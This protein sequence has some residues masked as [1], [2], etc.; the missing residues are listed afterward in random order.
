MFEWIKSLLQRVL[1]KNREYMLIDTFGCTERPSDSCPTFLERK[2]HTQFKNAVQ[3]YNII[4]VYGESRQGKTWTIERY[5][6]NQLR[7][8]CNASMD[9]NDLKKEMLHAVGVEIRE[10]EH[11]ITDEFSNS[12]TSELAGS[13]G[14]EMLASAGM[15]ATNSSAHKETLKTSYKTVDVS[16]MAEFLDAIKT[17]SEEKHFVFDN[18]HYLSPEIQQ[19][20][21]SLLKEFN[22]QNIKVIIVG[23]WKDASRITAMAPD[24]I[25]RCAHIDI[26][27]WSAEE[28]RMVESLGET[29][30]N[31]EI[32][33]EAVDL[34]VE[35][36]AKNIGIF[37][38]FLQR[39]CQKFE[40]QKT[41]KRK[42]MLVDATTATET[43]DEVVNESYTPLKD[44]ATNLALP[45]R[46]R[47]DSK[48]MR[49]KIVIALFSLIYE[50]DVEKI[51][52][53]FSINEIKDKVDKISDDVGEE[54]VA[55]SNLAQELGIIHTREENRQTGK[56]F[57]SLFYY[58]KANK[59]LLA[60]EPTIYQ[61]RAYKPDLI[62][63]ISAELKEEL[64]KTKREGAVLNEKVGD[65]A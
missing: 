60:L 1:G 38:D 35:C 30:L 11:S 27:T 44:R 45:Q 25:N 50:N 22:Y 23:V 17:H 26:G 21:C 46:Q 55:I 7:I 36:A 65:G 15:S 28:L 63:S 24:L 32:D 40:V 9:V 34:F 64:L 10:I 43:L 14:A 57:I 4:V 31:I 47:K 59:K 18:F 37:K 52:T 19:A 48:H 20:F 62:E 2:V 54:S 8:G 16:N 42:R 53:G 6:P 33:Q 13:V 5:C 29:A 41:E 58:D 39:Y 3:S 51:Q 49:Q 56:N 61:I 12:D